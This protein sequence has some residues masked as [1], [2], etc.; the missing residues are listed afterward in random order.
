M[1]D[2]FKL[3][4][5]YDVSPLTSS[6]SFAPSITAPINEPRTLQS[7]MLGD[8]A[9]EADAARA[10]QFGDVAN[11]NLI[12][13]KATGKVTARITS[14]D[15]TSQAIPFD[16]YLILMSETVPVTAIT[17]TRVPGTET[18]VKVFLGENA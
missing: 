6:L 7:K 9:L 18:I 12:I 15:G 13:L 5:S 4:G 8:I 10:V 1:A 2:S 11:A 16:T 17:L 3:T 14:A